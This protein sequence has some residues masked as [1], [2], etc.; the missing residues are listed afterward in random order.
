M[1]FGQAPESVH[2]QAV[3]RDNSGALLTNQILDIRFSILQNGT[4]QYEE[5]HSTT[6]NAF[7]LF[8]LSIGDGVVTS[9]DFPTIDWKSGTH[10]LK[11]EADPGSGFVNLGT[12]ELVSVPYSLYA[13][14]AGTVSGLSLDN[15]S[16]VNANSPANDQVLKWNGL[17]WVTSSD[18]G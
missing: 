9:G 6:T 4:L 5:V 14:E 10:Q 8:S 18:D 1:A 12:S 17:A 2:Y 7:G 15:L 13:K 3:A 11:V 16:D